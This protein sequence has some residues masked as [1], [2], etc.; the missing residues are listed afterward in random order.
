MTHYT[1]DEI[2]MWL[3]TLHSYYSS[4]GHVWTHQVSPRCYLW[5]TK[6]DL[7]MIVGDFVNFTLVAYDVEDVLK[8]SW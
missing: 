2:K 4:Y 5:G 8:T 3:S 6:A 1:H 7:A